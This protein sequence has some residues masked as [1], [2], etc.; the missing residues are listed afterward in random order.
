MGPSQGPGEA[1]RKPKTSAAVSSLPLAGRRGARTSEP[2]P[3]L[4]A[5]R[6]CPVSVARSLSLF[7]FLLMSLS[8]GIQ[9][10]PA[11]SGPSERGNEGP[12]PT[13][14]ARSSAVGAS[15][16][17]ARAQGSRGARLW[18]LS[19]SGSPGLKLRTEERLHRKS[20]QGLWGRASLLGPA[21]LRPAF[22]GPLHHLLRPPRPPPR[23][24]LPAWEC[25]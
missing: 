17:L 19:G 9:E 1:G 16:A 15:R 21:L 11:V 24:R 23:P 20:C 10:I 6:S 25:P 22:P 5:S 12:E 7:L 18:E 14:G 3:S 4:P 13:L 2:L 8:Q